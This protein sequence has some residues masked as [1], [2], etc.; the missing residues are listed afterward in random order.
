MRVLVACEFSGIVRDAFAAKGHDAW[1]CDILPTESE[2]NHIQ[3]NVLKHLDKS[4]DLMIA[5]PPCTYLSVAGNA[6]LGLLGSMYI[7]LTHQPPTP[8]GLAVQRIDKLLISSE[9]V[10]RRRERR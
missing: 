2:G 7:F 8:P 10:V 4:W 1:S 3:D 6:L 9:S 5:H